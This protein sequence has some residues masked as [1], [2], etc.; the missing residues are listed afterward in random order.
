M[1][2]LVSAEELKREAAQK[3]EVEERK[4]A[5]AVAKAA[6]KAAKEARARIPP[7]DFFKGELDEAGAPKYGQ[8][9]ADGVPT[10]NA[11]GEELGKG[12]RKKLLKVQC[13]LL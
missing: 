6:E 13:G 2:K 5:E 7:A 9:D 10:H 12:L 8:L 1:V 3:K 11:Q 4:A